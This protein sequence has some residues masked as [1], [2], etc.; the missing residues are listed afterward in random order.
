MHSLKN[1]MVSGKAGGWKHSVTAHVVLIETLA[2]GLPI[3]VIS[4]DF[5]KAPPPSFLACVLAG[6]VAGRC[7]KTPHPDHTTT[8][9]W[10]ASRN[11]R[12]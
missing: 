11:Q 1:S 2:A 9:C 5:F 3:W 10:A 12:R 7:I 6:F 8:L 4:A